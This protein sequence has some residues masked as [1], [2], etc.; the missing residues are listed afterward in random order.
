[1]TTLK[2]GAGQKV[3]L[4]NR[5]FIH[6]FLLVNFLRGYFL[7]TLFLAAVISPSQ[8]KDLNTTDAGSMTSKVILP[9]VAG[10]ERGVYG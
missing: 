3:W 6:L 8:A 2:P 9:R 4:A 7:Q 5:F 1:M 10:R